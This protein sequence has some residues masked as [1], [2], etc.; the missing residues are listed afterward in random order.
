MNTTQ[1]ELMY[2]DFAVIVT[3]DGSKLLG[4]KLILDTSV[5]S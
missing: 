3:M 1:P 4:L 2:L 5:I